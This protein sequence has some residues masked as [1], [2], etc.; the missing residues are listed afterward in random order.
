[1]TSW[2]AASRAPIQK[3]MPRISS[4]PAEAKRVIISSWMKTPS[5]P[6]GPSGGPSYPATKRVVA[7]ARRP[8]VVAVMMSRPSPRRRRWLTGRPASRSVK[9]AP[10]PSMNTHTP[11][12]IT[13]S[14][15]W[16]IAAPSGPIQLLGRS[17]GTPTAWLGASAGS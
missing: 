6:P 10:T 11:G 4:V 17:L 16:A 7:T 3:V 14:A 5:S 9:Y 8:E 13:S 15:S 12:P 2:S 1:M